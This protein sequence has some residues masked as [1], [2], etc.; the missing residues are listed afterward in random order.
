[1]FKAYYKS[2]I[3]VIEICGNQQGVISI[4]FC[5]EEVEPGIIPECLRDCVTQLDEYFKGKRKEFSV[6]LQPQGTAFQRNV[7]E[8]LKEIPYGAAIAY[9]DLAVKIGNEKAVRAVGHANSKNKINIMIPCHRVIGK[10]GDLTGYAGEVWRK[11]WLL[12]HEKL[13]ARFP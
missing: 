1:M 13:Y 9:T 12:E 7:W 3:G 8:K 6:V 4:L 11:K 10:N 2:Q 5:N